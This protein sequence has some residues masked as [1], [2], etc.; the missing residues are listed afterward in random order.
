M[1]LVSVLISKQNKSSFEPFSNNPNTIFDLQKSIG[2]YPTGTELSPY[3]QMGPWQ[4]ADAAEQ[5][6]VTVTFPLISIKGHET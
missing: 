4:D 1:L 6:G 3:H 5:C 2:S